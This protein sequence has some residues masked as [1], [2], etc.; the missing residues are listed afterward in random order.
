MKVNTRILGEIEVAPEAIITFKEGLLG[1][2]EFKAYVLLELPD[3]DRFYCLQSLE[4]PDTAFFVIR[5]WDFFPDY[6]A[7][8]PDGEMRTV[9]ISKVDQV[10]LYC[11]L[12]ISGEIKEMTANLLAPII[13]GG[14]KNEGKQV[15]L[16][17]TEY[18][19]KHRLFTGKGV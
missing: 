15:V 4:R 19:T 17:K 1:L 8:I 11:I 7:E 5:P 2:E 12:T 16:K 14:E 13:I 18:K 3:N 9:G 6:E 10:N